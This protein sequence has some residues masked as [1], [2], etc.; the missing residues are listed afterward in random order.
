MPVC[1]LPPVAEARVQAL[2]D[3]C[4][5]G[6][7]LRLE[8]HCSGCPPHTEAPPLLSQALSH[9]CLPRPLCLGLPTRDRGPVTFRRSSGVCCPSPL[10]C[11]R[12]GV[13]WSAVSGL[14]QRCLVSKYHPSRI[15]GARIMRT[16]GFNP[17]VNPEGARTS[18]LS[19]YGVLFCFLSLPSGQDL[20]RSFQ[21]LIRSSS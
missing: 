16:L 6:L 13:A 9:L 11:M 14:P 20:S 21:D 1:H 18:S 5:A 8:P 4:C 17:R 12:P 10:L 7:S 15:H 3:P 19:M 2:P